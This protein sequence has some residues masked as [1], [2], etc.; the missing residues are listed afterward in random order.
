MGQIQQAM[1]SIAQ[2]ALAGTVA[3]KHIAEQ[4][5]IKEAQLKQAEETGAL[6]VQLAETAERQELAGIPVKQ[7]ELENKIAEAKA[8]KAE[9]SAAKATEKADQAQKDYIHSAQLA[10]KTEAELKKETD[11]FLKKQL[12]SKLD[13][14]KEVLK[15]KSKDLIK[16]GGIEDKKTSQA[17]RAREKATKTAAGLT[18][19]QVKLN[20]AD[21]TR[22]KARRAELEKKY[23]GV[24]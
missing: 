18:K 24:K 3:G 6:K 10:S 14:E 17:I 9:E 15:D 1:G 5:N 11:P 21:L 20:Q 12:Q 19:E 4:K 16:K 8:V 23:G 13:I 22:L 2:T 7:A